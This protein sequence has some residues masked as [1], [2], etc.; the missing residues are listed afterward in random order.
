MATLRS[1]FEGKID[2]TDPENWDAVR[3]Q[4]WDQVAGDLNQPLVGDPDADV[5]IS[6][7]YIPIFG[8]IE[9]DYVGPQGGGY[10][11][12]VPHTYVPGGA[13]NFSR[14]PQPG[15]TPGQTQNFPR[16]W[17]G[18]RSL[19]RVNFCANRKRVRLNFART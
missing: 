11:F 3:A 5:D 14:K 8:E 2:L 4:Q 6:S 1:M 19:G 7:L 12:D 10:A 9:P 15:Y 17:P 18:R 13:H 16:N